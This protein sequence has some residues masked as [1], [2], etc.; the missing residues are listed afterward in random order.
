VICPQ[1]GCETQEVEFN[2]LREQQ[3]INELIKTSNTRVFWGKASTINDYDENLTTSQGFFYILTDD[4]LKGDIVWGGGSVHNSY[5]GEV[6]RVSGK[7]KLL[8]L[9]QF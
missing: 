6:A 7:V 4:V 1:C 3:V 9:G 2:V 5:V 8:D